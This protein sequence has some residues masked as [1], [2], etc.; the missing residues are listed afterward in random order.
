MGKGFLKARKEARAAQFNMLLK[1]YQ[2]IESE[3]RA[4]KTDPQ[5][6][7]GQFL[8]K[9]NVL[10][11]Q[12]SKLSAL[13]ASFIQI[14][15]GSIKVPKALIDSFGNYRIT[16]QVAGNANDE[17]DVT[18]YEFT[19][20]KEDPN[21]PPPQTVTANEV[22]PDNSAPITVASVDSTPSVV[23]PTVLAPE[24]E[25]IALVEPKEE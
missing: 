12:N 13:A 2:R 3:N 23:T 14:G 21:T 17:K 22:A 18:E 15:G 7:V 16:I 1:E 5:G 20:K 4:L 8:N 10:A 25:A 6:V 19:Y 24:E 9:L 11:M